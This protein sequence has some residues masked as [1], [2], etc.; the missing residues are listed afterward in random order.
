[1]KL[2]VAIQCNE[3]GQRGGI[4]TYSGR[5]NEY[6]NKTKFKIDK[7]GK[8]ENVYVSCE[9]FVNKPMN[10]PDII[11]IQYESGMLQPQQLQSIIQKNPESIVVTVHHMGFLPNFYPLID[12]MVLHSKNQIEGE[13]PWNY[14]VIPHPALVYPEKS[15]EDMREKY[16]L[17]KDKKILGTAGFIAGTGKRLPE[18]VNLMLKKLKDDEFL[19][20]ITSF[21]KGGD[22][23]FTEQIMKSVK[24]LG[25]ENQFRI[26]TEF[27]SEEELNEKMQCCDL[28]FAWN[29]MDGKGSNSG[30]GM[31][32]IGSRRKVI[33]KDS[34][35][36]GFV[37]SIE[38]VEV[39]RPKMEDF[40]KD[41]FKLFRKG[42][43]TK[44]AN[45]EPYS[46]ETLTKKYVEYFLEI[47]G[48]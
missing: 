7:D 2:K 14:T 17:P 10:K 43:L 16:D 5:L 47:L 33:V 19:Y 24:E 3:L 39:G 31:D 1:M 28:L 13:E 22:F 38:N 35:H 21:W 48:E 44:V 11:N 12:G 27:V 18:I 37:G 32:M 29:N 36:Y 30:I 45:P 26:D 41:T 15:K 6:L 20:L 23:G 46:W 9:Q 25:K 4:G 42:D 8:K 40:V 34:P